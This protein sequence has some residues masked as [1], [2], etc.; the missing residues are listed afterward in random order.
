MLKHEKGA[1]NLDEET[2]NNQLA[3]DLL[4]NARDIFETLPNLEFFLNL[5]LACDDDF[6]FEGLISIVR[7]S[8]LSVQSDLFKYKNNH[9]NFLKNR[10]ESLKKDFLQN[11]RE[12]FELESE[13]TMITEIELKDELASYKIFDRLNTEKITPTLCVWP[14]PLIMIRVLVT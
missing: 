12:I 7:N 3:Q 9:K 5:T 13:L 2:N 10:L 8:T 14:N 6:F 4:D 11:S 1:P